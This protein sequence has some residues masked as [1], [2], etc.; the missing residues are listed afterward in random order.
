MKIKF[1]IGY[2]DYVLETDYLERDLK[3]L[4]SIKEI[5]CSS[6]ENPQTIV[7][8]SLVAKNFNI[9]D[10]KSEALKNVLDMAGGCLSPEKYDNLIEAINMIKK[11]K[12][13]KNTKSKEK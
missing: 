5:S 9:I 2:N 13:L 10:M 7:K 3:I 8:E 4:S 11:S 6:G 1:Q 12:K